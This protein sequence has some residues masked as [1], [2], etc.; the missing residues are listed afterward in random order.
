VC[1]PFSRAAAPSFAPVSTTVAAAF[2]AGST[3]VATWF[4][5]GSTAVAAWFE[6]VSTAVVAPFAMRA[7]DSAAAAR[8][9]RTRA[10]GRP[11]EAGDRTGELV[12]SGVA[13]CWTAVAGA[14]TLASGPFACA[15]PANQ[16]ASVQATTASAKM[17]PRH[18]QASLAL[19]NICTYVFPPTGENSP[20][21]SPKIDYMT[22]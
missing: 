16:A 12:T 9:S 8:V 17:L 5:A 13:A 20:T 21:S 22:V 19:V 10:A 7:G 1:D 15:G 14:G 2:A 6:A 3:A 11:G 18:G 4:E